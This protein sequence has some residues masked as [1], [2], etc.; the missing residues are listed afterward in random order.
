MKVNISDLLDHY[1]PDQS[2]DNLADEKKTIN[3]G[4]TIRKVNME[5]THSKGGK[6]MGFY[7]RNKLAAACLIGFMVLSLG[8]IT[9]NAATK[10]ALFNS[11]KVRFIN[12]DGVNLEY[13]C[14]NSYQDS[15]GS[16]IYE[17]RKANDKDASL[18][19]AIRGNNCSEEAT[20]VVEDKNSN[21]SGLSVS[22][23]DSPDGSSVTDLVVAEDGSQAIS[24]D[25]LGIDVEKYN[26]YEPG[27]Y[28]ETTADG[29]TFTITV[30]DDHSLQIKQK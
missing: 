13:N 15:D 10:G 9:A 16:Q 18:T 4:R 17:Y 22:D 24:L 26:D 19:I 12:E 6:I 25:K 30:K 20:V 5:I 14:V 2:L 11:I 23:S 8:G 21:T 28:E 29:V 3:L 7:Y 1:T 27:T